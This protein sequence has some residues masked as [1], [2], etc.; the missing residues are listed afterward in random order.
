MFEAWEMGTDA[1][2]WALEPDGAPLHLFHSADGLTWDRV[3][4]AHQPS[5][6]AWREGALLYEIRRT[7]PT[8]DDREFVISAL[9]PDGA[10]ELP[11]S[12]ALRPLGL[13]G[14][15]AAGPLGLVDVDIDL[16]RV[17]FSPDGVAWSVR[18]G[19]MTWTEPGWGGGVAVG[20]D[21]VLVG[22]QRCSDPAYGVE[23]CPEEV[24]LETQLWRGSIAP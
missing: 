3:A 6:V 23:G 15:W 20:T 16:G 13:T 5:V 17:A 11:M 2:F 10:S 8:R 1:G 12:R 24:G 22:L 18:D 4:D 7:G 9:T 19:P 14:R 21:A